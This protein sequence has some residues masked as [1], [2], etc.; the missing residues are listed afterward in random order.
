MIK[1]LEGLDQLPGV[2]TIHLRENQLTQLDGFSENNKMLQ[3]IN[4]RYI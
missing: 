1:T 4:M 3:Y 2:T